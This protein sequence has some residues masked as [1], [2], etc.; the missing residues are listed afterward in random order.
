MASI[1]F[2]ISVYELDFFL[3]HPFDCMLIHWES[4]VFQVDFESRFRIV[5]VQAADDDKRTLLLL[6]WNAVTYVF[7]PRFGVFLI[8]P[9]GEHFCVRRGIV[10]EFQSF[11]M[12]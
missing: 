8:V 5:V 4:E 1:E 6:S 2:A 9:I 7:A 12:M 10:V 11:D 3:V